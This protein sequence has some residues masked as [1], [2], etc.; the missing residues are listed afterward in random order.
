MAA[1]QKTR[2][3][4]VVVGNGK[5]RHEV[6]GGADWSSRR[7]NVTTCGKKGTNAEYMKPGGAP[8]LV[9]CGGCNKG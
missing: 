1:E 4:V 5:L 9:T 7:E 8:L 2:R 3:T 6:R